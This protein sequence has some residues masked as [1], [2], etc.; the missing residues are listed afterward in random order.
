MANLTSVVE[1][2]EYDFHEAYFERPG[3]AIVGTAGATDTLTAAAHGLV[4][5]DVVSLTSIV[6]LTNVAVATRYYIVAKTTNTVQL[7]LTPGGTAIVIGNSGTVNLI[8]ILRYRSYYPNKITPNADKNTYE[9]KGGGRSV[10]FEQLAALTLTIDSASVPAYVHSNVFSKASM[11]FNDGALAG[12][13]VIGV[14]GGN[15]K[16]GVS[17]GLYLKCYAKKIV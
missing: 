14:G 13:N 10:K 7:A 17:V 6:T 5:G 11:T 3:T 16:S 1:Y 15:D 4:N 2:L 12:S 9:W 8:P